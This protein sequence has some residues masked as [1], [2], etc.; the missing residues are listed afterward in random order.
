MSLEELGWVGRLAEQLGLKVSARGISQRSFWAICPFHSDRHPSLQIHHRAK[1]PWL[2]DEVAGHWQCRACGERG[3]V[4]DLV[5]RLHP[6]RPSFGEAKELVAKLREGEEIEA[7]PPPDTVTIESS[8]KRDFGLPPGVRV[9]PL[10]KWPGLARKYMEKR[11]VPAWQVARWGIGYAAQGRLAGRVVL[12]VRDASGAPKSYMA[13]TFVGGDPKYL[14]PRPDERPD[15]GAL[16]GPF[17]WDTQSDVVF[18]A[19]GAFNA[20]AF[21]R[22]LQTPGTDL[23]AVAALGGASDL[24]AS[25]VAMLSVFKI[26][27]LAS[28]S[29]EAGDRMA[30]RLTFALGRHTRL[31]RLELPCDAD[32]MDPSE[33]RTLAFERSKAAR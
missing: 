26:V 11:N 20:L 3:S 18:A 15:L 32:E 31:A 19:E 25:H 2:E 12:P 28:D 9:E 21:E 10:E 29:D 30:E 13:R 8:P 23:P 4:F 24:Q 14:T 5:M 6:T 27:V 33:L 7:E 1:R 16:F 17:G 22:A